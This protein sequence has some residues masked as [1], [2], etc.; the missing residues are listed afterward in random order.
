[1][2]S[3]VENDYNPLEMLSLLQQLP[4]MKDY[5]LE[6]ERIPYD[7]MF[8]SQNEMLVPDFESTIEKLHEAIGVQ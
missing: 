6:E 7:G 3:D 1:M 5:D 8:Y 2:A 4:E